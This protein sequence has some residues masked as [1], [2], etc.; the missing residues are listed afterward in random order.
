LPEEE[1]F[2]SPTKK[3]TSNSR[4]EQQFHCSDKVQGIPVRKVDLF[5]AHSRCINMS[6]VHPSG[7]KKTFSEPSY[8]GTIDK[9]VCEICNCVMTAPLSPRN[10]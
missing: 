7:G 4:E 2:Q 1:G 8:P 6:I 9:T 10:G 5:F 3:I